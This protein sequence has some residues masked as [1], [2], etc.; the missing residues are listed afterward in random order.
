LAA[1]V[2]PAASTLR[3][4][5]SDAA[6]KVREA[7]AGNASTPAEVLEILVG[8]PKPTVNWAVATNPSPLA[9]PTAT[10]AANARTRELAAARSR[11]ASAHESHRNKSLLPLATSTATIPRSLNDWD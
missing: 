1:D 8:D 4:L 3:E 2:T 6:P 10:A 11:M 9:R 7:V 5:A